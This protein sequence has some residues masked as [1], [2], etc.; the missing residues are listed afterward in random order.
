[1]V[2]TLPFV[3]DRIDM[4][5]R[6]RAF[7]KREP[8]PGTLGAYVRRRR[9]DELGMTQ[10]ELANR[11]CELGGK[12]TQGDVSDLELSNKLPR[13]ANMG[14]LADALDVSL[15]KLYAEAG[16]PDHATDDDV[17]EGL[18]DNERRAMLA[19]RRFLLGETTA[20]NDMPADV[21]RR[22]QSYRRYVANRGPAAPSKTDATR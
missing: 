15:G 3:Y 7:N 18:S 11:V 12:L 19:F 17:T 21:V 22:L 2:A 16:Y 1:M 10:T 6:R 9:E 5:S 20:I 13:P 8:T 14:R 4:A